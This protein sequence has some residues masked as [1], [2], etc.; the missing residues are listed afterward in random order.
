M[1][2]RVV[3][4]LL[5]LL[6]IT[7]FQLYRIER[8]PDQGYFAKY[9]VFAQ[10]IS[11]GD[12]PRERLADLSPGYVWLLAAVDRTVGLD[13]FQL[14][15]A[16]IVAVSVVALLAALV[17]A[18]FG[19]LPAAVVAALLVLMNRAALLNATEAEP[20][21]L[22]LLLN[23]G[24]LAALVRSE[25][26]LRHAIAGGLLLGSSAVTRPVALLFLALFVVWLIVRR[27]G[28][29]KVVA[30]AA[31]AALPVVLIVTVNARLTG[32]AAIMD[33]GTVFYEGMNPSALGYSGVQPRVVNDL[34]SELQLPDA[35]HVAYRLVAARSL[36]HPV[37]R[38]ESN[39]YWL[40]RSL[41]FVRHHPAAA[42][43]LIGRKFVFALQS[44]D[45]SDLATIERKQRQL[46]HFFIPFGFLLAIAAVGLWLGPREA[47]V[48]LALYAA[49]SGV[50]LVVFYVTAR[51][52][53]V[54]L[55][56]LAIAAGIGAV[57]LIELFRRDRRRATAIA[58]LAAASAVV[59]SIPTHAQAEEAYGWSSVMRSA[60]LRASAESA[61]KSGDRGRAMVE[62]AAADLWS[63][64]EGRSVALVGR[65]A[66]EALR[67]E[68][69]PRRLFDAALALQRAGQWELAGE[70]L[71]NLDEA[72]YRPMRENRAVGS[73]AYYRARSSLRRGRRAEALQ[74]AER[75]A[76]EAPGDANVLAL[77]EVLRPSSGAGRELQ[78]IHDGVTIRRARERAGRDLSDS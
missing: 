23:A 55:P 59:L 16:Q 40:S 12:I 64:A 51:Q 11:A 27:A 17:A 47:T 54:L 26:K 21:T 65:L 50:V 30:F 63:T 6:A 10:Q 43:R 46:D 7:Y 42:A 72:G 78:E 33:P 35:L 13:F 56:A 45:A 19:G 57:R 52:R 61:E 58:L 62:R 60:E 39:R 4:G 53:N 66:V 18:R 32:D 69:D 9:I 24:T 71:E 1:R 49:A 37:T 68:S 38:D 74:L 5:L 28:A 48:P 36:G 34:E 20:E 76:A 15:S 70:A 31:A 67:N 22:I 77:L 41:A 14:R 44:Y 73:V 2:S 3:A 25:L 29:A 75:A 8:L